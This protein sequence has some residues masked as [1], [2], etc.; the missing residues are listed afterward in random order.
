VHLLE[1]HAVDGLLVTPALERITTRGMRSEYLIERRT[2]PNS[3]T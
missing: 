1:R 2:P 3:R